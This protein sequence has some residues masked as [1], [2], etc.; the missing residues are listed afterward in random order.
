MIARA[1]E[2]RDA[3]RYRDA[4]ALYDEALRMAPGNAGIHVQ[5]GHM[6]KE[7]GV[8]PRAELHY[9]EASRLAPDDADLAL[10]L[11]HF[12]KVAG[13]PQEASA[14][15]RR[16]AALR[17]GWSAPVEELDYLRSVGLRDGEDQG[18]GEARDKAPLPP[19]DAADPAFRAAAAA[20]GPD[21]AA[22]ALR[23]ADAYDRLVPEIVPRT[24][25]ELLQVHDD[26]LLIRVMGRRERS[27]WGMLRT[28]RGVEAI[29]GFY[30][31]SAPLTELQ[32]RLNG[33][34]VHRGPLRGGYVLQYERERSQVRKY[35]FNAW[36]DFSSYAR[37]RH[38]IELRFIGAG[39]EI[40]VHREH[41]VIAA[42]LAEEDNP[43]SNAVVT[44]PP[45][46]RRPVLEQV[47]DRP[48][49]VRPPKRTLFPEPVRNVLVL[50]TDQLGDMVTSIPAMRRLR[51]ILPG[52]NL[53]GL[54]T[55][56]NAEFAATLGLFDEI[57][58][59]DF[60]DDRYQ[61]RRIMP[62]DKQEELRRKLAP[63]RFDIAMDLAEASISRPLLLLSGARFLY[64]FYDR[65]WP[66]LTAG[67]EANTHDPK[68]EREVV[69]HSTRIMGFVERLGAM[70][71]SKAEVVRRP[72]LSREALAGY[73]I[74]E[75]DRF[76]VLHT[77]ARIEAAR[78]PH[79]ESL[80]ALLLGRTEL[81]VVY[82]SDDPVERSRLPPELA[83]SA[84]FHI[85]DRRLPFD[86]LDALLQFCDVFVGN[87]S[88]P[89][90]L[91]SLRGSPVVSVQSARVGWNEWGQEHTGLI[92]S[93]KVPCAGCQLVFDSDECG[94]DFACIARIT[95][96]EVFDAVGK[97]L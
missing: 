28:L 79:Y 91:A 21:E 2:A 32:I 55:A 18:A 65:E 59:V 88:G 33:L 57:I 44:L 74:A 39:Q 82:M 30:N 6:F 29:R 19:F 37:G 66:W 27:Y 24:P 92:I 9:A 48:S 94:Q 1:D 58:V 38:E 20:P 3:K 80:A 52:A 5:C 49:V 14:A 78:W 97:V 50:R 84:R 12:Y 56:A 67:Y 8:L 13:R 42:P 73:G 71:A 11:G 61:R 31:F 26:G 93:R 85:L 83:G 69:P 34:L 87:D 40:R 95:P 60:P 64:G 54:V 81:R 62:L 16:A 75:G 43:E 76:A 90:H 47:N 35:V 45:G 15:Y 86:H 7:A 36:L 89:K 77:G 51:E 17:P 46:D 25:Y 23:L 68:N 63:Y 72:D 70:L 10:Q 53:V 41:V 22:E 96:E 4:A